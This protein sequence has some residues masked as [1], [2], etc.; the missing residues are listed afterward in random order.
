MGN[1]FIHIA[2]SLFRKREKKQISTYLTRF[3]SIDKLLECEL[4]AI[5]LHAKLVMLDASLHVMHM[6][7]DRQYAAFFDT[8]RAYM[9]YQLGLLQMKMIEY[10]D[11]INF[12]VIIK[13]LIRYDETTGEVFNP[14]KEN[15]IPLIVGF[16]QN[17]CIDYAVYE[18]PAKQYS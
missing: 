16:Y 1:K 10:E 12:I 15:P 11:K 9:N 13:E 18:D 14:A 6:E 5:D 4:M 7:N 17:G 2:K 8:L 3:E